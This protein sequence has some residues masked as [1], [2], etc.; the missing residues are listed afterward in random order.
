MFDGPD[1]PKTLD[2]ALFDDWLE[3]GRMNKMGYK[4]LLILWD[5]IEQ[6]YQPVFA[7]EKNKVLE[8][9]KFGESIAH[10][11]LIAMLSLIHI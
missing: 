7:E 4:Y 10:E 8:F 5:D 11:S 9:E 2:E 6:Q 1:Y 3:A